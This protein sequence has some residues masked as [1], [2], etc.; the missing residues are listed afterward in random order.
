[1]INSIV[2]IQRNFLWGECEERRK[3][4]WVKWEYVCLPKKEGGLGVKNL[5]EFNKALLGK[6]RWRLLKKEG[7]L[8]VR[9][10]K[11]RY[12]DLDYSHMWCQGAINR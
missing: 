10:V 1:M 7:G 4:A 5:V 8:W 11:S 9:I 12:G 3:I 2:K 6:W